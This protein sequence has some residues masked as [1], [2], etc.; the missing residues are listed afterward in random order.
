[1]IWE[2]PFEST[3][4]HPALAIERDEFELYYQPQVEISSGG[5]VG[6]EALIRWNHPTHGLL[7]PSV[8][9]PIAETTG[10]ILPIGQWVIEQACRQMGLWRDQGMASPLMAVNISAAQFKLASDLDRIVAESLAKFGV[11]PCAPELELTESVLM[12]TTQKHNE[13]LERLRR[14]GVRLAIDDFGTGYSSLSYL[15]RFPFDRIKIDKSFIDDVATQSDSIEIVRAIMTLAKALGMSTIAE[16]VESTAQVDKL[17]ELGCEQIQGYVFS[18][19]RPAADVAG[20]LARKLEHA[21]TGAVAAENPEKFSAK[22]PPC[23]P[24]SF[25]S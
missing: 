6:L 10:S 23:S 19:P 11:P 20:L 12:E 18:P 1:M 21:D 2:S 9:I 5:V 3:S 8:F 22:P 13:V 17:R 16:G 14:L 24:W 4:L 15:R 25:A 7:L